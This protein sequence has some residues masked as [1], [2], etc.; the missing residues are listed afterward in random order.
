M[1]K[2]KRPKYSSSD[3]R[4]YWIGYGIALGSR[5]NPKDDYYP[6]YGREVLHAMPDK[7]MRAGFDQGRLEQN[8]RMMLE[9]IDDPRKAAKL[10]RQWYGQKKKVTNPKSRFVPFR[11]DKKGRV[12]GYNPK[13]PH[14]KPD[15]F[16]ERKMM[17][18]ELFGDFD[19]DSKGRIKGSYIDGRF[20]PD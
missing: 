5:K 3:K 14:K 1:A 8:S 16:I 10:E 19:Y 15:M 12:N 17:Q 6:N 18:N 4:K 11:T 13:Y 7:H 9:R 20:E 2:G